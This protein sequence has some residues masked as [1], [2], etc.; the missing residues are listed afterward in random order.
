MLPL[1]GGTLR[2]GHGCGD[3]LPLTLGVN[4]T[5]EFPSLGDELTAFLSSDQRGGITQPSVDASKIATTTLVDNHLVQT[6]KETPF[7]FGVVAPTG[8]TW[9]SGGR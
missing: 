4:Q 5:D 7:P 1:H 6:L 2:G 3:D 8:S 9:S